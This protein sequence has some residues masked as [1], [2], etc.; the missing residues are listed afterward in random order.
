MSVYRCAN[1]GAR[2]RFTFVGFELSAFLTNNAIVKFACVVPGFCTSTSVR[3]F[4][5]FAPL[6]CAEV[7][8]HISELPAARTC[9][10]GG[11]A[12]KTAA[13]PVGP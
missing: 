1:P 2:L 11:N 5:P 3:Q 4:A 9:A 13:R 12:D 6:E 8:T 7:G 10:P